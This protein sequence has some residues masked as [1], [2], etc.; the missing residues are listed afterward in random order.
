MNAAA[1][2]HR[3]AVSDR[4][5][6]VANL[7]VLVL[8]LVVV[9]S[10]LDGG[11]RGLAAVLLLAVTVFGSL[12]VLG[13]H[14]PSGVPIEG[15]MTPAVGAVAVFGAVPL[16]EAL[17]VGSP[18]PALVLAVGGGAPL[19]VEVLTVEARL[20]ATPGPAAPRDRLLVELL[21]LV[22]AF[23]VFGGVA[24]SVPGGL[25]AASGGAREPLQGEALLGLAVA[26]ALAGFLLGYRLTALRV[27]VAIEAI[28]AGGTYAAVIGGAAALLW[29]LALP[30]LLGPAVLTGLLYLWI[31][32][33]G[34][35]GA[36]RREA[37]WLWEYAV[38][39]VALIAVVAWYA[40]AR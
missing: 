30:G 29:T 1:G 24:A 13:E 4:R 32:Y 33:R 22:F 39:A 27:P 25:P 36:Q 14:E 28:W 21:S 2:Y 38:L 20:L 8:A 37:R 17:G 35:T 10:F 18:I 26:D 12:Q 15:L 31:V 7:V 34:S 9:G 11:W 5:T 40:F 3:P 6:R 23:L 19:L 16:L